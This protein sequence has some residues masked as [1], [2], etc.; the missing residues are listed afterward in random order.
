[1]YQYNLKLGGTDTLFFYTILLQMLLLP[2]L[3]QNTTINQCASSQLVPQ[4]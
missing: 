1:M 2:Y 4:P 3:Q